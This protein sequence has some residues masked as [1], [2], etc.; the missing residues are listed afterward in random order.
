MGITDE[1]I[2]GLPH[3]NPYSLNLQRCEAGD[4]IGLFACHSGLLIQKKFPNAMGLFSYDVK[5]IT[6]TCPSRTIIISSPY[7]DKTVDTT[8]ILTS[9]S[10]CFYFQDSGVH[11]QSA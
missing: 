6:K 9:K 1:P 10:W 4:S 3:C 7:R 2:S 11:P 5:F 8:N